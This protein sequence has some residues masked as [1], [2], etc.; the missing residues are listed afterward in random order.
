MGKTNSIGNRGVARVSQLFVQVGGRLYLV[1]NMAEASQ[2]YSDFTRYLGRAG[3]GSSGIP[4]EFARP[5]LLDGDGNLIGYIAYNGNIFA[6]SPEDWT[7]DT[8]R[9]FDATGYPP[10]QPTRSLRKKSAGHKQPGKRDRKHNPH[11]DTGIQVRRVG[12]QHKRQK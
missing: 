9:L 10:S 5:L 6:G 1:A 7:R 4:H 8:E 3:I 2:R 12:N 11:M